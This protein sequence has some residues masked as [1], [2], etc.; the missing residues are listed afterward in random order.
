MLLALSYYQVFTT[1]VNIESGVAPPTLLE[2]L[3]SVV[4]VLSVNPRRFDVSKWPVAFVA[5]FL[6]VIQ[7][8]C[9]VVYSNRQNPLTVFALYSSLCHFASSL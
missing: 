5:L 4:F 7:C 2:G 8:L 9:P 1:N 3:L 6:I